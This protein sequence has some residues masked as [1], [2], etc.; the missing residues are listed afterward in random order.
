MA[1]LGQ[2]VAA[3]LQDV[4]A[5]LVASGAS[6]AA[7]VLRGLALA[8]A[9][10]EVALA[11]GGLSL[12]F[13]ALATSLGF[14]VAINGG[15]ET[16]GDSVEEVSSRLAEVNAEIQKIQSQIDGLNAKGIENLTDYCSISNRNRNRVELLQMFSLISN[17]QYKL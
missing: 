13:G 12:L 9:A 15:T 2:A 16:L 11:T 4:A 8:A 14:I 5:L 7:T 1:A 3:G 10:G 17:S 6:D